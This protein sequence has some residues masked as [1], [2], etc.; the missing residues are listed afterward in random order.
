M[1]EKFNFT[2][3]R[4]EKLPLP[5]KGRQDY[6]D[7]DIKKLIC[8][9]SYT[10]NKSFCITKRLV[11]GKLQRVTLGKYPDISVS[12]AR[13]LATD[14]L[15]DIAGGTDLNE[16]KRKQRYRAI[17]LGELLDTYLKDKNELRP[18]S[19]TDYTKKLNQ[20]FSDWIN[21]PINEINREMVKAKR[22]SF[23][24]GVDN[25]MRVLRLLM[26]YAHKT[27]KAIEENPVD[28][29]TDGKLWSKPTRKKRKI[30]SDN[31]KAWYQAVLNLDNE[32][33][34]VYLI[35]LLHTGL[36][37]HDVRSLKW[38]DVDLKNNSLIARDTKNNSDF[39]AYIPHQIKP[40]LKNLHKLTGQSEFVFPG[41]G[42]DGL[43]GIPVKP[44]SQVCKQAQVSFS[45]HD[46]KR[47]FLTI[48][49]AAS[50]PFSLLKALANHETEIDVTEGYLDPESETLRNATQ[51]IADYIYKYT[52]SNNSNITTL[53]AAD[54]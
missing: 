23:T 52:T 13:E 1:A 46:L 14:A 48:G 4:I 6:Y 36:R 34:K 51:K 33:A 29:L 17:T 47:T 31:L 3:Q 45:S 18:A 21:K 35:L 37:D 26:G 15:S 5:E 49:E 53:Q 12:K 32:K 16:E 42:E 30:S 25:K 28:V 24:G 38:S 54:K 19:V 7:T 44:I 27:L 2:Q 39:T 8:R 22:N 11:T 40:H 9:V 43:M 10:G 50:V 41:N 20:G